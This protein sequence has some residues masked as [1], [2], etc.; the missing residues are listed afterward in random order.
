[1]DGP[2]SNKGRWKVQYGGRQLEVQADFQKE[3]FHKDTVSLSTIS[4][5]ASTRAMAGSIISSYNPHERD[6][7]NLEIQ[8]DIETKPSHLRLA[9]GSSIEDLTQT[10]PLLAMALN[11]GFEL[12]DAGVCCARDVKDNLPGQML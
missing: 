1:K 11:A 3:T 6:C 4:D 9:S 2:I 7:T 10:R 12:G 8:V 5:N